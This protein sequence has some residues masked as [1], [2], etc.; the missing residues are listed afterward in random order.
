MYLSHVYILQHLVTF[1][2]GEE[3]DLTS[4]EDAIRK[5]CIMDKQGKIW[6][7]EMLLQVN[8]SAIK[9]LDINTKVQKV[10]QSSNAGQLMKFWGRNGCYLCP[11]PSSL[12]RFHI[13][14]M[15]LIDFLS[16]NRR[17]WRIM[18][19]QRWL[20]VMLS[21]LSPVPDPCLYSCA[22]KLLSSDRIFT[23]LTVNKLG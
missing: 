13:R 5:L 10:T 3:D 11:N 16:T 6:V 9:L 21:A 15:S 8:G 1:S 2:I 17:N 23:S 14:W 18:H 19:W 12:E 22:R 7:Q 20:I 4:V